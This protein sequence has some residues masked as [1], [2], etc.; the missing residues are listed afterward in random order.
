MP[1]RVLR[2]FL[3]CT[4][5]IVAIAGG[6]P[7]AGA[8]LP[9]CTRPAITNVD[10]SFEAGNEFTLRWTTN[11]T[12]TTLIGSGF[13]IQVG[14]HPQMELPSEN[15]VNSEF[16]TQV[17]SSARQTVIGDTDAE[18]LTEASH[19]YHVK[20]LARTNNCIESFWSPP[21][22]I[23]QDATGPD[24]TIVT[25]NLSMF[26][27]EPV[28][29]EGTAVDEPGGDAEIA[30]GAATVRVEISNTTPVVGPSLGRPP[31]QTV[32]V[33]RETGTW[34]AS[35]PSMQP[36]TYSVRA[37]AMDMVDNLSD[38]AAEIGIIVVVNLPS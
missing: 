14:S 19:W 17:S 24:V 35:F 37:T 7:G 34:S 16:I 10:G 28:V 3:L 22:M 12:N 2:R 33:D 32:E 31:A 15:F 1:T 21:V 25:G 6:L 5:A 9:R 8:A 20:A 29:I 23:T 4:V 27:L 30:S 26:T 38:E 18:P 11:E 13:R 36:G